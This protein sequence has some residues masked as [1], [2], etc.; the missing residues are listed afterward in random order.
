[1][2]LNTKIIILNVYFFTP[3]KVYCVR[4][5]LSSKVYG[6]IWG[7]IIVYLACGVMMHFQSGLQNHLY[8]PPL[9]FLESDLNSLKV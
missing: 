6:L 1:M 4:G 3:N 7:Y 5:G 9:S 8:L 2:L